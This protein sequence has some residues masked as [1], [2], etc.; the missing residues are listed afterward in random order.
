MTITHGD[1]LLHSRDKNGVPSFRPLQFGR[2]TFVD[3]RL[4]NE[5]LIGEP[6]MMTDDIEAA[7]ALSDYVRFEWKRIYFDRPMRLPLDTMVTFRNCDLAAPDGCDP[8]DYQT[9]FAAHEVPL[10]FGFPKRSA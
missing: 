9:A 7:L 4:I 3:V 2:A 6:D 5:P 1:K 10:K 8:F